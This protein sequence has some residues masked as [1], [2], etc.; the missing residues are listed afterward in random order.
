MEAGK[1]T[2]VPGKSTYLEKRSYLENRL[3]RVPGTSEENQKIKCN[4]F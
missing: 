2:G 1:K 3:A 4:D